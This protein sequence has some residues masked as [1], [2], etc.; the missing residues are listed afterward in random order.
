MASYV[1]ASPPKGASGSRV[2]FPAPAFLCTFQPEEEKQKK[3]EAKGADCKDSPSA[4][5]LT[6]Q[7]HWALSPTAER[8]VGS[9]T[10]VLNV[11]G[12]G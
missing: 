9:T 5:S 4:A 8:Q 7:Y 10:L 2:V 1:L 12:P 11:Y 3:E 6:L